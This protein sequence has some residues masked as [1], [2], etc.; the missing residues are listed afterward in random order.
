MGILKREPPSE[1]LKQRNLAQ[2]Q[3]LADKALDR[4]L[5]CKLCGGPLNQGRATLASFEDG[6]ALEPYANAH[7]YYAPNK[8]E[9]CM[10]CLDMVV[11]LAKRAYWVALEGNDKVKRKQ[12]GIDENPA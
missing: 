7:G 12:M 3:S 10:T 1:R 5:P 8:P 9:R 2:W 4:G 11:A 6:E